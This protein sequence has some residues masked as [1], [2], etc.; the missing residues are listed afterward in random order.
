MSRRHATNKKARRL[1]D[2]GLWQPVDRG[3]AKRHKRSGCAGVFSR[4]VVLHPAEQL[5][6]IRSWF[7]VGRKKVMEGAIPTKRFD[8]SCAA[9]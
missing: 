4:S 9:T 3:K 1:C 7:D 5:I 8:L 2:T 6:G